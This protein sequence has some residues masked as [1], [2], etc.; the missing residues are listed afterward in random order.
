MD[1]E[2]STIQ[3]N[4]S[5][6][7]N[8][9]KCD[10]RKREDD[11]SDPNDREMKKIC[12][13]H[14][15]Q[16]MVISETPSNPSSYNSNGLGNSFQANTN[17][18][19]ISNPFSSFSNNSA[20]RL[21]SQSFP[22]P[23]PSHFLHPANN[24][25]SNSSLPINNLSNSFYQKKPESSH[26]DSSQIHSSSIIV[27]VRTLTGRKIEIEA[28]PQDTVMGLKERIQIRDG[29]PP[30]NQRLIFH[31]KAL[32]DSQVLQIVGIKHRDTVHLVLGLTG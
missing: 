6:S 8:R 27:S 20:N 10:K 15:F 5:D 29:I 9:E 1:V 17:N 32:S 31:G 21:P 2:D 16:S 22:S 30:I 25:P 12:D 4:A 13:G 24:Y 26:M 11:F 7:D 18:F 28:N 3:G 14:G 19:P 23:L